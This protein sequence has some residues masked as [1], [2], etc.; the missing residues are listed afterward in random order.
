MLEISL[1]P[2]SY[3]GRLSAMFIGCQLLILETGK[4]WEEDLLA[5]KGT[6]VAE[7]LS[8]T[9]S[10]IERNASLILSRW[11]LA[12]NVILSVAKNLSYEV[13][14]FASLGVTLK[15]ECKT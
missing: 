13:R 2:M 3:S 4:S 8:R 15:S 10:F 7:S 5:I 12:Q 14:P 6:L 1:C 9:R 11:G